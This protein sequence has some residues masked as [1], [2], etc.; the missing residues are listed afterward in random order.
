MATVQK[1]VTL[2]TFPSAK[3]LSEA[4]VELA[5]SANHLPEEIRG[6]DAY[7]NVTVEASNKKV[8]ISTVMAFTD[9]EQVLIWGRPAEMQENITNK[10]DAY[11]AVSYANA[12]LPNKTSETFVNET[13][14]LKT[15]N[16]PELAI[17]ISDTEVAFMSVQVQY[18]STETLKRGILEG[19]SFLMSIEE[20][21]ALDTD[22]LTSKL[23]VARKVL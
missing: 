1:H 17:E 16:C 15:I 23:D 11:G 3:N 9:G 18:V 19:K 8:R 5:N 7:G 14:V 12:S 13:E 21:K 2:V 4:R 20:L 10:Y 22:L 6:K